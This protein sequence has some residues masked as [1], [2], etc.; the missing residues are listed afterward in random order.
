MLERIWRIAMIL[1][2][3]PSFLIFFAENELNVKPDIDVDEY[4]S[5]NP[6]WVQEE[7]EQNWIIK[8]THRVGKNSS[9]KGVTDLNKKLIKI[10]V[11]REEE[12]KPY[13]G[14]TLL[15]EIGH[16]VNSERQITL[17]KHYQELWQKYG[18]AFVTKYC[19]SNKNT[20][21]DN[22]ENYDYYID[23]EEGTAELYCMYIATNGKDTEPGT[24]ISELFDYMGEMIQ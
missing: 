24:N 20:K 2:L 23:I 15:H 22:K 1:I 5:H 11:P 8:F 9:Y 3:V 17:D 18:S 21:E 7:L 13:E 12:K 6:E 16:V 10:R 4:I 19:L 14:M